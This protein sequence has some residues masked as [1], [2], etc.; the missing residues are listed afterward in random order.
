MTEFFQSL[1][2]NYEWAWV[3]A[4]VSGILLIPHVRGQSP[5]ESPSLLLF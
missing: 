4:T 1:G 5:G 3:A 2:M